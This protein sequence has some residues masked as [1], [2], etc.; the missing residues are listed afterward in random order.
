[1][2]VGYFY[3]EYTLM[4]ASYNFAL[5]QQMLKRRRENL[6]EQSFLTLTNAV[7]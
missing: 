1:M 4:K 5:I 3:N 2:K 6:L 7:I